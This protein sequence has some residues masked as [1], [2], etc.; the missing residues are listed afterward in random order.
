MSSTSAQ[1]TLLG[2]IFLSLLLLFRRHVHKFVKV[3]QLDSL[4]TKT[5]NKTEK[6]EEANQELL[7]GEVVE[8]PQLQ[9]FCG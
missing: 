8:I 4:V 1:V 3:L 9:P 7:G 2:G 6:K 5:K